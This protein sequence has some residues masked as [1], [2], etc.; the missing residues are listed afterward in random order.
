MTPLHYGILIENEEIVREL[1][2]C[3]ADPHL[4]DGS[5]SNSFE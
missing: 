4:K 3:G 1:V 2:K 5:G